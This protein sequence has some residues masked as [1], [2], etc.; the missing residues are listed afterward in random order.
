MRESRP[1]TLGDVLH[2]YLHRWEP[3]LATESRI[4]AI[5]AEIA[6]ETLAARTRPN[7]LHEGVLWVDVP[8][9]AW[10][11]ELSFVRNDLC[12]KLANALGPGA[13]T[14]IRF[15]P[16]TTPSAR[17]STTPPASD[18]S[19][20]AVDPVERAEVE[21]ETAHVEDLALREAIRGARLAHAR[22]KRD[23]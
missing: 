15:Q 22:S 17:R 16:V 5:W 2:A 18:V 19:M 14:E 3:D 21:R 1:R 6:G 13:L 4:R 8:S 7:R 11:Q 23:R 9:A 12:Q 10:A 20:R